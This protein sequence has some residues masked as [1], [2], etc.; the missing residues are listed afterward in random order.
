MRQL[1]WLVTRLESPWAARVVMAIA[2][3]LVLPSLACPR[4]IDEYVQEARWRA[5]LDHVDGKSAVSFLDDCFVFLRGD[6]AFHEQEM[7]HG[8]GAWWAAPEAKV[9][10]WRPLSAATHAVDLL[11]W[12]RSTVLMHAHG[13]LWF[14][15]LLVALKALYRRFLTP[16]VATLALALY[17]WDDARGHALSWIAKRNV[18]IAGVFGVC[19][20]IA[21]D[22]Y[23]RD[24]WRPGAW[25][26]PL[27]FAGS[28]LSA[29]M[30]LA[31]TGFLFAHAL[32]LDQGSFGRRMARLVPYLLV[33]IAWQTVYTAGGYG[34]AASMAYT[35]P[36]GE[37]LDYVAAL[38]V[39]AP[40][41]SLGQLTPVDSFLWGM[42]PR[43]GRL[44]VY[45]LALGVLFVV[46]RVAW[47]RLGARPE[48]RFWLTGAGLALL[49]AC[50]TGPLDAN[51]VFVGLGAAPA[52]AM[53]L[54]SA[55]DDPPAARSARFV[56]GALAAFNLALAPVLLPV[57][58]LTM[59]AMGF[60]VPQTDQSI[61]RGADVA[62]AT[63]VVAWAMSEGGLYA[64]MNHRYAERIPRPGRVRILAGSVAD[65]SATRL[66]E[67]TLRMRIEHGFL[68]SDL[69][70]I[71]R[72][73]AQPFHR[74]D[75]VKL[76]NM[77]AAVTEVTDDGRPRTVEFRFATPLESP[78]W[79]WMRGEGGRLLPWTPP[80][81]GETVTVPAK[82]M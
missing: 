71:M 67:R 58:S 74:G 78:E 6:R 53:L 22:K 12:P 20:L 36:L 16:G 80:K 60:F 11:L 25:L 37:P 35:H 75:L 59:L 30:A 7:E 17:A 69:Q 72:G 33:V 77:T 27:L 1:R 44:A 29:E 19:A 24:G 32:Y 42:Y 66:D 54:R 34:A 3:V 68:D 45:L 38:L 9:A 39:R 40:V 52:L 4:F 8:H 81:I 43:R 73:P 57:K 2:L 55:L 50:A 23:R 61:P 48:A 56:V 14:A 64:S 21:H 28:L 26:A 65:V 15:G 47:P 10:F 51:L 70:R 82:L 76:S 18:L 79:L 63:L 46:G 41:L 31:V 49:P 62:Q 5:A 13:L